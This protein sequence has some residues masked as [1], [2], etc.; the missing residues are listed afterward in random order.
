VI[1]ACNG[2]FL[3]GG[4]LLQPLQV[5]YLDVRGGLMLVD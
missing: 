2:Q 1:A 5:R 3:C 4:V